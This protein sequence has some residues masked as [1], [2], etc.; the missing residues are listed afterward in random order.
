MKPGLTPGLT[1][2][3]EVTVSPDMVAHFGGQV[4]H[5]LFSTSALV[6][7]M[8]WAARRLIEPFLESHEEAMANH[9]E[10][11]H[12]A[13]TLPTTDVLVRATLTEIRDRKI[14]CDVEAFN[15]RGKLARG[16][17]TQALVE[18][19]WLDKKMKELALINQLSRQFDKASNAQ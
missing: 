10:V 12:L 18:K 6:Q 7:S 1:A 14:I 5:N 15:S 8:E 17:V 2:E 9:I 13:M 16:T 11:S 4:V 19:T 3:L